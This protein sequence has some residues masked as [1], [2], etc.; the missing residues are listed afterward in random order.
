ME[1]YRVCNIAYG[2]KKRIGGE[3]K[4]KQPSIC[5]MTQ[6][7]HLY[8]IMCVYFIYIYQWMN[9]WI[10]ERIFIFIYLF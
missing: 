3:N 10:D 8:K 9:G 4:K 1:R 6:F 2:G 5:N 7:M